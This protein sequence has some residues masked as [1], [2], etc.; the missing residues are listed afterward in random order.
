MTTTARQLDLTVLTPASRREI[1]AFY[2]FLLTRSKKAEKINTQQA[3]TYRFADLCGK[4]SWQG[5][6]VATQRSMRDEW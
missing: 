2:Q 5:D 3:A 4:L 1:R 6:A